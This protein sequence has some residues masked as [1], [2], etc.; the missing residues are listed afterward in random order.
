V[1]LAV[2][3]RLLPGPRWPVFFVTPVTLL[4]WHRELLARRWTYPHARPGRPPVDKQ[5]RDLVLRS[6]AEN[7]S[8][9]HRR[10]QGS[11]VSW[12]AWATR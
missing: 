6:A 2:L 12:S 10:I 11:R 8:C 5:I 9:G 1:V 3:S 7:A 4:C